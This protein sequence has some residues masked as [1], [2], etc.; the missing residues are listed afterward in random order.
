MNLFPKAY[1]AVTEIRQHPAFLCYSTSPKR[2]PDENASYVL[3]K[4]FADMVDANPGRYSNG[5][6][7]DAFV[8]D[9]P[10]HKLA[11]NALDL[12]QKMRVY[13]VADGVLLPIKVW[14]PKTHRTVTCIS[15]PTRVLNEL[16]NASSER[17]IGVSALIANLWSEHQCKT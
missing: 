10:N 16:R 13:K 1:T 2:S 17:G 3:M 8:S 5:I 15:L 14:K 4:S 7:L 9:F 12:L 6:A 11:M